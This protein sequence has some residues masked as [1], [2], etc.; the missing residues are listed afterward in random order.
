MKTIKCIIVDDEPLALNLIEDY[1]RK[2]PFL[3]LAAKSGS[4]LDALSKIKEMEINLAF[5][6]IQ[7]PQLS[8]MELSKMLNGCGVIFTTAFEQY[9]VDSYKVNAIDYLLK[10]F[11]Y[12]EFLAAADKAYKWYELHNQTDIYAQVCR[13]IIV[14]SEYRQQV[15]R[16][17]EIIY[18]ESLKDYIIIHT[19]SGEKI[20]TLMSMKSVE[21][22]LPDNLFYRVSRSFIV[23]LNKVKVIE[24]NR[25][26]F[27]KDYIPIS[28]KDAFLRAVSAFKK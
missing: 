26:V 17:D 23:N 12:A 1:V 11:S 9:A 15:I 18:I 13:N 22:M 19:D 21:E 6:D 3:E 5:L 10:P 2:T 8:G 28:D 16:V 24:R 4:A 14:K 7:M 25:V 27:G 20:Q